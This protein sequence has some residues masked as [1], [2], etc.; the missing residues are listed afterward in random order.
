MEPSSSEK[1]W[2]SVPD[3]TVEL[4]FSTSPVPPIRDRRAAGDAPFAPLLEEKADR[5]LPDEP[6][7]MSVGANFLEESSGKA[8]HPPSS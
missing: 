5:V 1:S 6:W 8:F 4:A 2:V 3:K 7:A